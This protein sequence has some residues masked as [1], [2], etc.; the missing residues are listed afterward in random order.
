MVSHNV[1]QIVISAII[2]SMSL[3]KDVLEGIQ[4]TQRFI[5]AYVSVIVLGW[6]WGQPKWPIHSP[7]FLPPS[8]LLTFF[9][10]FFLLSYQVLFISI[11]LSLFSHCEALS[12]AKSKNYS[13]SHLCQLSTNIYFF[14]N[15]FFPK[16]KKMTLPSNYWRI[17]GG[18]S[19]HVP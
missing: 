19:Q 6:Q 12:I 2:E 4:L 3:L 14:N 9:L 8:I 11:V 10:Y 17:N 13:I 7:P 5:I 16:Q 18:N 1:S 15:Y